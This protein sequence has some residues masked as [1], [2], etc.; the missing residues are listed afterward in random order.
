MFKLSTILPI[1]SAIIIIFVL[2]T[3]KQYLALG[4]GIIVF[5]IVY[6]INVNTRDIPKS[7]QDILDNFKEK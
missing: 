6:K 1:I 2:I 3:E 7:L 4:I 5:I